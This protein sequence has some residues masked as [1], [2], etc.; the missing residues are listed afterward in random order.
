MTLSRVPNWGPFPGNVRKGFHFSFL[1][2]L[3]EFQSFDIDLED[4][5]FT[6]LA[7]ENIR[8][9]HQNRVFFF[10]KNNASN[11][12]LPIRGAPPGQSPLQKYIFGTGVSGSKP[13]FCCCVFSLKTTNNFFLFFFGQQKQKFHFEG[14]GWGGRV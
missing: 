10:V 14:G 12:Y 1:W 9:A 4:L 11:I 13:I 7:F 6:Q 2:E 5:S 8:P 3:E